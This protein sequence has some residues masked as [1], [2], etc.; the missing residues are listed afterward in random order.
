MSDNSL[1]ILEHAI[2]IAD[3]SLKMRHSKRCYYC[4]KSILEPEYIKVSYGRHGRVR[5]F[6][7]KCFEKSK[8]MFE[9]KKVKIERC[10]TWD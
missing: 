2:E 10:K 6:H 9:G 1:K 5:Y 4:R 7:I 3:K 8:E